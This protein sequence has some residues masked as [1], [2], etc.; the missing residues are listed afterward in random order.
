M[1]GNRQRERNE[2]SKGGREGGRIRR[3]KVKC[4][5][6]RCNV[7]KGIRGGRERFGWREFTLDRDVGRKGGRVGGRERQEVKQ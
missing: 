5:G 3:W 2:E 4:D 7:R 6:R 1:L